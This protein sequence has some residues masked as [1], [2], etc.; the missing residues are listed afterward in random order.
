MVKDMALKV[1]RAEMQG[2]VGLEEDVSWK[3]LH[4]QLENQSKPSKLQVMIAWAKA[5]MEETRG[6][7]VLLNRV[8]RTARRITMMPMTVDECGKVVPPEV[9][10]KASEK[11]LRSDPD[12]SFASFTICHAIQRGDCGERGYLFLKFSPIEPKSVFRR[13]VR[14]FVFHP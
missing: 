1:E 6:R 3:K 14:T 13:G 5:R 11:N 9:L 7:K 10:S 8:A 4:T 2:G 12:D